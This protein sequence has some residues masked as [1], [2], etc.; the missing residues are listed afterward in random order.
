MVFICNG[1][2]FKAVADKKF[3]ENAAEFWGYVVVNRLLVSA[4][5]PIHTNVR[6]F[7]LNL[8]ST[9]TFKLLFHF[10]QDYLQKHFE[11]YGEIESIE[12]LKSE[13]VA[14]VTFVRSCDACVAFMMEDKFCSEISTK[15]A[16]RWYQPAFE[17]AVFVYALAAGPIKNTFM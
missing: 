13:N 14:H 9:Q 8:H 12:M 5:K 6:N 3:E 15:I 17:T 2:D 10:I 7:Y 1:I 4:L 16:Q 11:D